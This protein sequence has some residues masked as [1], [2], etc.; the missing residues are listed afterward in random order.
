[1]ASKMKKEKV[2]IIGSGLIGRSWA[3]LFAGVGYQVTIY[4]IIPDIVEKALKE[5]KQELDS[6]E[7]QG[8]LRGNLTAAEQFACISGTDNLKDA[9]T[10]AIYVQECVPERLDI[11]KKL[12]GE[13]DGLV[14][15]DT[16]L[17][18]ST[19]TF[20][21]SLFSE[22]MK[23]RAQVL[24]AHPVN[25]PY[26]VPLV[27]IVPAPWTKAEYTTK[28][29][30][31]M[32][33]I[34]QKPVTLSRQIEGFALNRIQ[35]AILNETWRLVADGI[36]N[37]KDIDVVMSEGLGMR[38]AFLGPLETA[39]LNAEG[40]LNYCERYCNTIYAVSQTMGPTPRMEGKVAE[41]VAK[42]MEEM[43][44]MKLNERLQIIG[45]N[46]IL[47]PYES[48]HVEKYH[49]WMKSEELQELTASEPLTLEEEY[50]MQASWRNDEDK[51]TFLILDRQR[52]DGTKDEIDALIGDTNIFIQSQAEDDSED[53]LT[54]EIEIMIAEPT[55]RGKRFGWEAT[56]LMLLFGVERLHLQHF[57]AITK[58]TNAKAMRM[59]ERMKFRETKRT[60]IFQEVSFERP[61]EEEWISWLRN[62]TGSYAIVPYPFK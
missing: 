7:K 51:C 10:D 53:R 25:P 48:K 55:A 5:T 39:H 13:V 32:T 47:V 59:F 28:A 11:K 56:L 35:Y 2:A 29:R 26:Y 31:L 4:D 52:Y 50:Q 3:M 43:L 18:S 1:M 23:H 19:S 14:G 45:S 49:R 12:Y 24:V 30:D 38:Y 40:M 6:I 16:I 20:M 44:D 21:P 58:D 61:V 57:I 9:I 46:V 60:P 8:L 42:E 54:G 36:L 27:E 33:E 15:P 17:A 22:E 37:V 41:Q 34:G 62:E